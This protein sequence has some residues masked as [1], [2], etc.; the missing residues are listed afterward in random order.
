L[1]HFDEIN[2]QA[3]GG[4]G[5]PVQTAIRKHSRRQLNGNIRSNGSWLAI[6][7]SQYVKI[8]A[9]T[10]LTT[11]PHFLSV[12]SVVPDIIYIICKRL[13]DVHTTRNKNQ[14]KDLWPKLILPILRNLEKSLKPAQAHQIAHCLASLASTLTIPYDRIPFV[15]QCKQ[16]AELMVNSCIMDSM[17]EAERI[18]RRNQL[19][20]ESCLELTES[21]VK[22]DSSNFAGFLN[23]FPAALHDGRDALLRGLSKAHMDLPAEILIQYDLIFFLGEHRHKHLLNF[24]GSPDFQKPST[25]CSTSAD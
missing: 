23:S 21:I 19:L 11:I 8:V 14:P 9:P 22:N 7:F 18:E 6:L 1:L 25:L 16:V 2:S 15:K 4:M 3:R 5:T 10:L 17:N 20:C 12:V 24:L 13:T